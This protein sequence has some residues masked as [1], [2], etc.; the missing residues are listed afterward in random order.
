MYKTCTCEAYSK[1]N[2]NLKVFKKN[3]TTHQVIYTLFLSKQCP[4]GI[5]NLLLPQFFLSNLK[6]YGYAS[7][8]FFSSWHLSPHSFFEYTSQIVYIYIYIY[9]LN[10]T[11][12]IL[13]IL[14]TYEYFLHSK[15]FRLDFAKAILNYSSMVVLA[16]I[17]SMRRT[18]YSS[19]QINRAVVVNKLRK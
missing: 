6:Q 10:T 17:P 13:S 19:N 7:G 15:L 12:S 11:K 9:I 1:N 16:F 8:G 18:R 4:S 3:Y 14:I 5:Q 2:V